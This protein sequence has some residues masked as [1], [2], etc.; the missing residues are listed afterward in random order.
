MRNKFQLKHLILMIALL[1]FPCGCTDPS[2]PTDKKPIVIKSCTPHPD[3]S[4]IL[5]TINAHESIRETNFNDLA[6][7]IGNLQLVP[8]VFHFK[9]NNT[10]LLYCYPAQQGVPLPDESKFSAA[11]VRVAGK[12]Y[13][14]P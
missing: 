4:C 14:G 7:E 13:N 8:R 3:N 10:F 5:I 2:I 12:W 6:V 1:L 9:N 11:R